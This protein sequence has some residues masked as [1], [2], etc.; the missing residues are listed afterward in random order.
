M[1][2]SSRDS[3]RDKCIGLNENEVNV[4]DQSETVPDDLPVATQINATVGDTG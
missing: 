2:N 3:A 1:V 4:L